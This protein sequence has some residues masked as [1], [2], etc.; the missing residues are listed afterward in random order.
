M[1]RLLL[2]AGLALVALVLAA[3]ADRIEVMPKSSVTLF[4][5]GRSVCSGVA[6][7][8]G[9]FLTA[10]HCT[11]APLALKRVIENDDPLKK[12]IIFD[13]IEVMLTNKKY[14]VALLYLEGNEHPTS[15]LICRA[16]RV[17]ERIM[18]I[19]TPKGHEGIHSWGRV[20]GAGRP[21]NQYG[22]AWHEITP[23]NIM[24]AHGSSGGPI[25]SAAGSVLGIV[26]G[27]PTPFGNF[28]FMVPATIICKVLGRPIIKI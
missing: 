6:I 7:G 24:A 26:V 21:F 16:P 15:P 27:G 18:A 22:V 20:A 13:V 28:T 19:T 17:G 5:S 3:C 9:Y 25:Y 11:T 1:K 2:A 12:E 4:S 8:G 23:L 10:A 14:D